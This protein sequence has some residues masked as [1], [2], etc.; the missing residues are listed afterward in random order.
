MT[1]GGNLPSVITAIAL[2]SI[3]AI[4]AVLDAIVAAK[5][6]SHATV[7]AVIINLSVK[8]PIIPLLAGI[9]LGHFFWPQHIN[10]VAKP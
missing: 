1:N 3:L 2:L 7:S 8:F 6:G 9:V 4:G 10:G 5:Y